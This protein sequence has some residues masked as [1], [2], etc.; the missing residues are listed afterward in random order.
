[1]SPSFIMRISILLSALL[2]FSSLWGQDNDQVERLSNE[3][4]ISN[5]IDNFFYGLNN[6][7]TT[8]ILSVSG[9]NMILRTTFNDGSNMPRII[10]EEYDEFI[11]TVGAPRTNKWEERISDVVIQIDD[12]LANAWMN[13]SFYVDSEFSHCGVNAFQFFQTTEGW[14]IISI[15]DTRRK[16]DCDQ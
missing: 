10:E 11:S 1:M 16:S 12:N 13:Y 4:Q 7:D 15:T 3:D 5:V 6:G 9:E 8:I 2:S 14:K